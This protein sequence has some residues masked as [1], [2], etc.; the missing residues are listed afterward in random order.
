MARSWQ[1]EINSEA[2][3]PPALYAYGHLRIAYELSVASDKC[4][5]RHFPSNSSHTTSPVL[6]QM[7][8]IPKLTLS[9]APMP[10]RSCSTRHISN[11]ASFA[12]TSSAESISSTYLRAIST[13][14]HNIIHRAAG[15]RYGGVKMR[16]LSHERSITILADLL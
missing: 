2:N 7:V 12:S 14:K 16:E 9:S 15:S 5:M 11:G 13:W 4:P 6:G 3:S 10:P 8:I 1:T